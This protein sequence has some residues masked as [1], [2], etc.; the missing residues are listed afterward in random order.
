M[1]SNF[2]ILLI[3]QESF[4]SFISDLELTGSGSCLKVSDP[5][6][7][8]S[9]ALSI[10][11]HDPSEP[12]TFEHCSSNASRAAGVHAK[13]A[14]ADG[15]APEAGPGAGRT[16][17][18]AAQDRG[19]PHSRGPV[20]GQIRLARHLQG[21]FTFFLVPVHRSAADPDP[22]HFE[23][24]DPHP[25]QIKIRIRIRDLHQMKSGSGSAS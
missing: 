5:P 20:H 24:P 4:F 11:I 7:S 6:E 8:N 16:A 18:Q 15:R 3:F 23:N 2:Q 13:P 14:A 25:Q 1:L 22:H 9:P 17:R 19:E 21:F 10:P 12:I